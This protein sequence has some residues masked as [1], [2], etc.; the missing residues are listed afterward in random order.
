MEQQ[1]QVSKSR[2][3]WKRFRKYYCYSPGLELGLDVSRMR[4]PRT[5]FDKMA[6]PMQRAFQAMKELESGALAN[7]DEKRQV[8]HYW[9][10]NPELA[11]TPAIAG[12][13]KETNSRLK[14]FA[15]D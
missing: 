8:G 1:K 9:L 2:E 3:L 4:F 12:E 15:A 11:P 13:I 5:F 7:P 10:R 14:A 6:E